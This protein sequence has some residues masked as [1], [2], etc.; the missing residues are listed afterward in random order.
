M[1]SGGEVSCERRPQSLGKGGEVSYDRRPR[2]L[3]KG[4]EGRCHVTEGRGV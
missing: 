2:G 4:E 1:G 3:G